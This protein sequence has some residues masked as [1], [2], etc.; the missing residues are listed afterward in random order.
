MATFKIVIGDK[1]SGRCV[2]KEVKDDAAKPLIGLKIGDKFKGEILDLS[3][4]E[5][6]ITGGSD[7]T[8]L[9]MRKDVAGA[10]RKRILVGE[11]VGVKKFSKITKKG[12]RKIHRKYTGVKQR[13]LVCGNT[14]HAKTAQINIKVLVEGKTPLFEAKA[15]EKPQSQQA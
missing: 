13:R 8:G 7:Y 9:P 2:Q 5:F 14:I 12:E 10:G 3:G 4:Y 15:E 6:Q 11:G 1:K